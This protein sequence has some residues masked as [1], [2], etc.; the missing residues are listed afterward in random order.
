LKHWHRPAI[1]G[2]NKFFTFNPTC[3]QIEQFFNCVAQ[4]I[5]QRFPP[6][7]DLDVSSSAVPS[8]EVKYESPNTAII[9]DLIFARSFNTDLWSAMDLLKNQYGFKIQQVMTSGVGSVGNPTS[10]YILMTK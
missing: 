10:V 1:R 5:D 9:G 4:I 3:Y 7:L 2:N 8:V 6:K